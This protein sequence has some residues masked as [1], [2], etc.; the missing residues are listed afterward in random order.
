MLKEIYD[1]IISTFERAF[2]LL[3]SRRLWLVWGVAVALIVSLFISFPRISFF[4]GTDGQIVN[5]WPVLERQAANPLAT[6]GDQFKDHALHD[7]K[8]AFRLTLPLTMKVLHIDWRGLLAIQYGLGILML[9]LVGKIAMDLFR[10]RIV[11]LASVFGVASIYA[12]KAAFLQLG[13]MG[14]AFAFAFLTVAVAFRNPAV[15]FAAVIA[16]CFT[17]ERAVIV[18]P[19]LVV[20]WAMRDSDGHK[21]D[22]FNL[23]T[24]TVAASI[25]VAGI[26]RLVL[27]FGYGLHIPIGAGND[28]GLSVLPINLP[29]LQ[30]E[31]PHVLAGLWLWPL[32]ACILLVRNRWWFSLLAIVGV[33]GAIVAASFMVLDVDRSLAYTLPLIYASMAVAA[34]A[35]LD[36]KD[37][38]GIA[39][40]GFLISFAC[41]VNSLFGGVSNRYS[42]GN[43]MPVEVVRF[44]KYSNAR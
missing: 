43:L 14:D 11:A 1:A 28:V 33:T 3:A 34:W 37:L 41:P 10:D 25:L 22:W 21:P 15:I 26:I 18:S 38:R 23:Q 6:V 44:Y 16:A 9:L 39:I 8:L 29:N 12:G 4:L 5:F 35:R 7:A 19:L 32:I 27:M 20:Y 40:L 24:I 30:Y 2:G 42:E 13:G 36:L 17:D 31:L